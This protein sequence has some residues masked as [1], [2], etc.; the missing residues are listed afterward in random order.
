MKKFGILVFCLCIASPA[1]AD[2]WDNCTAFEG[3][4][5]SANSYGN[6]KGGLCNDPNNPNLTNN[7]NGKQFC[8]S[9]N[10]MNWWTAFIWCEAIGGRLASFDSLCPGIQPLPNEVTG[11]CP[12]IKGID[13]TSNPKGMAGLSG[14]TSMGYGTNNALWVHLS[15]GAV[16]SRTM[17]RNDSRFYAICEE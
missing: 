7:C 3:K 5:V 14:W 10:I 13:N 2:F 4:I 6:D 9:G 15:S 1:F 8:R 17:G 16:S 11:A 12:N